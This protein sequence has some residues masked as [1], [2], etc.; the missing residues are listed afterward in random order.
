MLS[1]TS[2]AALGR[3]WSLQLQCPSPRSG[4]PT[5]AATRIFIE[6]TRGALGAVLGGATVLR[7]VSD[8]AVLVACRRL[9]SHVQDLL[10]RSRNRKAKYSIVQ[11]E[12]NWPRR[13]RIVR[14]WEAR[15]PLPRLLPRHL[16]DAEFIGRP[17]S[18]RYRP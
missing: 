9:R 3:D 8:H 1:S 12:T 17:I 18:P 7:L 2:I 15:A 10:Q 6:A 13:H 5:R 11:G 4:K 14:P 16:S